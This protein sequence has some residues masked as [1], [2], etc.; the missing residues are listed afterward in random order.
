MKRI[1]LFIIFLFFQMAIAQDF[2]YE[3]R[4]KEIETEMDNG[5]YK[6]LLPKIK[7]IYNQAKKENNTSEIINSIIYQY[8]IISIT[9]EDNE[10]DPYKLI[11]QILENEM[12]SFNGITLSISKSLLAKVYFDYSF[13]TKRN[14]RNI[15]NT[16][17]LPDDVSVWNT[18]QL[19]QKSF[20]LYKE[21]IVS[22]DILKN[23]KSSEWKKILSTEED[24]NLYPTLYD[25]LVLRYI[26]A[27]EN[28]NSQSEFKSFHVLENTN[29]K[30]EVEDNNKDEINDQ[31]NKLL[32][33]HVNDTDKSAFLAIKLK[34]IEVQGK[35]SDSNEDKVNALVDLANTYPTENFTAYIYYTAA[36][37]IEDIDK[38]K[39]FKICKNVKYSELNPW[40][41]NCKNFIEKIQKIS[42]EASLDEIILPHENIPLLIETT[43]C[44][45]IYYQ[46]YQAS[47]KNYSKLSSDNAYFF[48]QIYSK[49]NK[50]LVKEG[51][52]ELKD[53]S[54]FNSHSTISKLDGLSEGNYIFEFSNLP[55]KVSEKE[56]ESEIKGSL[57]FT[58]NDWSIIS[59]GDNIDSK[60]QLLSRKTGKIISNQSINLFKEYTNKK[61]FRHLSKPVTTKTD[62]HGMFDLSDISTETEESEDIYVYIP[63]SGS[64]IRLPNLYLDYR[65]YNENITNNVSAM[66][67]DRT[68]YRPGQKVFFKAI[69]YNKIKDKSFIIKNQK[70]TLSLYNRYDK[71]ISKIDLVSNDYGSVFGEFILPQDGITGRY[72]L[73]SDFGNYIHYISVEEYKRPKF[74]ITFDDLNGKYV[75]DEK[76]IAKGKAMSY[77]G[78]P[79]S[80]AKLQYRIVRN[81]ILCMCY[82][83]YETDP[84]INQSGII[85]NGEVVTDRNGAFS[86]S[87]LAK[88]KDVKKENKYRYYSYT[89]IVDITDSNGETHSNQIS[90]R[91]GDVPI[92]LSLDVP[93]ESTQ[94]DFT[95]III[96]STNL[97]NVKEP[98]QGLVK[99]FKLT[100]PTRIIL[101]NKIDFVPDYQQYDRETFEHYFPYLSYSKEEQNSDSWEKEIVYTYDYNTLKSD[102]INLNS[103]LSKGIY[104]VEAETLYGKDTIR[105]QKIIKIRE[106]K[107]LKYP[108]LRFFSVNTSQTSYN[109]GEKI[110]INFY[111][112]LKNPTAI[113]HL[114][115]AE[116]WILHKEIPLINGKG[117]YV[118]NAQ[119]E[120]I[121]DGLYVTSYLVNENDYQIKNFEIKVHD[122]PKDLQ[123]STKVFRDKLTP[124]KKE[125]WELT[126]SGKGKEKITAEVLATLYDESLDQFSS[127]SYLFSPWKYYTSGS[128]NN[129]TT[130][131][132]YDSNTGSSSEKIPDFK[133]KI[134]GFVN[135]KDIDIISFN[136]YDR[137]SAED[138]IM[139]TSYIPPI[140]FESSSSYEEDFEDQP[141][142]NENEAIISNTYKSKDLSNV[143]FRSNFEETAF[144]FPNLYTNKEGDV[145]FTFI[146]PEALT[147]WKLLI[148]A[149][150]QDLYSG[151]KEFYTQTQKELM[152]VPNVPRFLR[153]GDEIIISAKINSLLNKAIEGKAQLFL[154]DALT[155]EPVDVNFDNISSVKSFKTELQKNTEVNWRIKVPQ[156]IEA[157]TYRI[158]AKTGNFTDG[159]ENI[160]PILKK[161]IL[162]TETL[163]IHVKENQ[164]KEFRLDKLINTTSITRKNNNLSLEVATNPLW[165]ALFSIPY[166]REYPYENSEQIFSR[167][168]G[169]VLASFIINSSPKIKAVLNDWNV[170]GIN[171]SSLES[172]QELKNILLEE[173]P[174]IKNAESETE[175]KKRISLFFNL[176]KM[177]QEKAQI[178]DKLISLQ[179]IDG[180]FPWFK[181]GYSSVYITEVIISG[182]GQLRNIV[183][184]DILYTLNEVIQKAISYSDREAIRYVRQQKE[185]K[186]IMEANDFIHYYYARSFW[187]DLYPLPS[188]MQKYCK[189]INENISSYLKNSDFQSK[190]MVATILYRYGYRPSALKIIKNLK[191]TSVESESKG[192]YWKDN[193]AGWNRYQ[194]PIESQTK[195]IEAFAEITPDDIQSVEEMKVWLLSNRQTNAWNST[196]ATTHAIYAL[197]N[198]GK[199]WQNGGKN[200]KI[201][202]GEKQV[203]PSLD[204][205]SNPSSIQTTGY[206]KKSWNSEQIQPNMG[207]IKIEKTSPGIL[208]G[209]L[210]W[211]YFENLDKISDSYTEIKIQKKLF[212]QNYSEKGMILKEVSDKN[213]IKIGDKITIRLIIKSERDMDFIHIKDMR[214]SGFEPINIFSSYKYQNGQSYY[215]ST[216]D[217]AT[218]FFFEHM[219]KGTYVFEYEV[220]A[221]NKGDFSNGITLV[222]SMYAPEM[223]THSKNIPISIK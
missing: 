212:I 35:Y 123:I 74:E 149:H 188:E 13:Y 59:L 200:I 3:K 77:N 115:S 207:I 145:K 169:N 120:F 137:V 184:D 6:S 144:F 70:V 219:D 167:L 160:I 223:S 75:L 154:F 134:P 221:N 99:I 116:K 131:L 69:L 196:K 190:A 125:T 117:T 16:E 57:Y 194:T 102:I 4:W 67:T 38:E 172:N 107:T 173:T 14:R 127:N 64:Y 58:V 113:L 178:Q 216:R 153:E 53:F 28:I 208:W 177:S 78:I 161:R 202:I 8:R 62:I 108:D 43:N 29:D 84:Y 47:L 139:Y 191:E 61:G 217:A 147:K 30:E 162:V 46:I 199:D 32:N 201:F 40:S 55:K 71:K 170:K 66:F 94:K 33:F 41:I 122:A 27:L 7:Q 90:V 189:Q 34:Q 10:Y 1:I 91:V 23:A 5:E 152:I 135:I 63:S 195:I 174:W 141:T 20:K 36:N 26:K 146:A 50:K 81:D 175:Q 215:E 103:K 126:I 93:N 114:E 88:S 45:K 136:N 211:Q 209:G 179:N 73:T 185:N 11:I 205:S 182:L 22:D 83:Y 17:I 60:F 198:F 19:L 124:G 52:I 168:F 12:N 129:F 128:I 130:A 118:L 9:Q 180:G 15:S 165:L 37:Q 31:L 56:R 192:M 197:L 156:N 76:V 159:E 193:L 220:R 164:T 143:K 97:N 24:I 181:G 110:E 204:S 222:Q 92:M 171:Q 203:S 49:L 163:P 111:S 140:N 150:T 157:V 151:T 98:S 95:Q 82:N 183:N 89:L 133:Y 96:K 105:D 186:H 101:P 132:G 109:V 210:Y 213:A 214:A 119:K 80:D 2:N 138:H 39:A 18:E 72:Y 218:N 86:I 54:D 206:F 51:I 100:N 187:K 48:N 68:I 155:Q 85:E 104:L 121:T 112:D 44:N 79:I 148:L 142:F 87:F 176:N 42:I 106:D 65:D 21:S 25:I 166:L 158:V